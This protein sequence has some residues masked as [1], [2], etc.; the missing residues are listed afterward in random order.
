MKILDIPQSGK[1]GLNVNY[2]GRNGQVS[3]SLAIPTNPNTPAQSVV[4]AAFAQV[5]IRWKTITDDQRIAW[6]SAASGYQTR[7]RLGQSG[8]MTGNQLYCK[9]NQ[10]LANI[11]EDL[12]DLPP[13]VPAFS[14]LA[15]TALVITRPSDTA[16]LK[17]TCPANPG[18]T[19]FCWGAPPV[20]AG[21]I[22][23][24]KM[25]FLGMVPT[26]GTGAS[27]ITSI[28]VARFAE[29]AAGQRVFVAANQIVNGW[30]TP[31]TTFYDDSP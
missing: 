10:A 3:R 15:V 27:D 16:V 25:V 2:S 28:Y 5:S 14:H 11:G 12:V 20:S 23:P 18:Q 29:P 21:I 22:R 17:L 13:A 19:T 31:H 24:P 30:E 1:R 9:I 6:R 4:R 8:V 26:P 7:T